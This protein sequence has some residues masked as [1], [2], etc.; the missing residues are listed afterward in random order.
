MWRFAAVTILAMVMGVAALSIQTTPVYACSPPIGDP[1]ADTGLIIE[2]RVL[3]YFAHTPAETEDPKYYSVR[4]EI[5]I[6]VERVLVG[7]VAGRLVTVNRSAVVGADN[8]ACE[9]EPR[10]ISGLYVIFGLWEQD[11]G[12]YRIP[13]LNSAFVG[14]EP[15]GD[16]YEAVLQRI[17]NLSEPVLPTVGTDTLPST[18]SNHFI[19]TMA[20]LGAALLLASFSIRYMSKKKP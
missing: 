9:F 7:E 17:A 11:D 8:A 10:D 1:L 5:V 6:D 14:P 4:E 3:E 19:A 20:V 12:T 16:M 15:D 13:F 2:G 18:S